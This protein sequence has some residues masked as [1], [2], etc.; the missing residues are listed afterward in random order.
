MITLSAVRLIC[1]RPAEHEVIY[2]SF[3]R[4]PLEKILQC[5]CHQFWN[6]ENTMSALSRI[7]DGLEGI[8]F[9]C[10]ARCV[11]LYSI[12]LA[13]CGRIQCVT[14]ALDCSDSGEDGHDDQRASQTQHQSC[15]LSLQCR[16]WLSDSAH[17]VDS[18]ASRC[19]CKSDT[20]ST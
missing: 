5:A 18:Q 20:D 6:L 1:P 10:Q 19:V 17:V 14:F 13:K 9:V 16:H 12:S 3:R 4:S 8:S 7:F 2:T 11:C 15:R